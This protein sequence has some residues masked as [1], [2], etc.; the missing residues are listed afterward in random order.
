MIDLPSLQ[1]ETTEV[2]VSHKDFYQVQKSNED[3]ENEFTPNLI[4]Q[5]FQATKSLRKKIESKKSANG[6]FVKTSDQP[7]S[8]WQAIFNLEQIKERN[9]P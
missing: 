9:K 8:K 7:Y 1:T 6:N 2:K 4:E 5:K 3:A